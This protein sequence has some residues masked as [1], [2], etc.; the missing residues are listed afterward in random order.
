MTRALVTG[1]SGFVGS[2]LCRRL[3]EE[4]IEVHGVS[5]FGRRVRGVR[6]W[7]ADLTDAEA[8]TAVVER[9]R[10]DHVFHLASEVSGS[11]SLDAVRP[12]FRRNLEAAVNV[13]VAS[14]RVGCSSLVLA[15][16]M[17]EP[18]PGT[19]DETPVS[20][21]A[22]AKYA[23]GSYGRML[24]ALHGLPVVNVRMFMVYGPGQLD[25]TKLVPYTITSLLRA[26]RP[27]LSSGTREVDWVFVEDVVEALLCAAGDAGLAGRSLD[28]GTGRLVSV[29]TVVE[30][31]A[32]R[33]GAPVEIVF[34]EIPE[35]PH[36]RVRVAD[37]GAFAL[38]GWRARTSL[39][40]GLDATVA[41]YRAAV[42]R[43][44]PQ[45]AAGGLS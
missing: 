34:G 21:Y 20:P 16:S 4:G 31:I 30:E 22:A 6:W 39:E 9:V 40:E 10:A 23:A 33:V 41:W 28:A 2:H 29:R 3:A 26:E 27:R 36:E 1:A 7:R 35:R 17:E 45:G 32:E 15:G 8:A 38:A 12:T 43:S 11:R 19:G 5:R 25:R 14:A 24:H 44:V 42:D 37:T 18:D 13:M